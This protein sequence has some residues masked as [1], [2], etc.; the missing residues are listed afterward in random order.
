MNYAII[1]CTFILSAFVSIR[2]MRSTRNQ[3]L[4]MAAALGMNSIILV[5]AAWLLLRTDEQVRLFGID[6]ANRFTL[7]LALPFI[8]W[9][10]LMMLSFVRKRMAWRQS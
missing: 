4:G 1:G 5:T 9:V 7:I 3:W 10:H 6:H 8:T 2:V